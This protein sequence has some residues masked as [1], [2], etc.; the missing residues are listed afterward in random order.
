MF[1]LIFNFLKKTFIAKTVDLLHQT[2]M[3]KFKDNICY[4]VQTI[5]YIPLTKLI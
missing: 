3:M 4:N 2:L 5:I 1:S